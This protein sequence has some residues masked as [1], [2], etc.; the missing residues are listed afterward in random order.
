M[1][2]RFSLIDANSAFELDRRG[3]FPQDTNRTSLGMMN[4]AAGYAVTNFFTVQYYK[5]WQ[6]RSD[7]EA[8]I[9]EQVEE[10]EATV[11][12]EVAEFDA[13]YPPEAFV[14]EKLE[15]ILA[16][17]AGPPVESEVQQQA[18][19]TTEPVSE[20][21]PAPKP[22]APA[23]AQEPKETS[24]KKAAEPSDENPSESSPTSTVPMSMGM[25][26]AAGYREVHRTAHDDDGDEMLEDNEDTVIY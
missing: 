6:L 12:R 2:D 5:P 8:I 14:Y 24:D 22:E 15:P 19:S 21:T 23:D 25:D 3:A 13:R 7:D 20:Q 10:A 18:K 26:G 4:L 16:E 17:V 9:R 11:A 1:T